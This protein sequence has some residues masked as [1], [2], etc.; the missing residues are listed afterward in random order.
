Q[1][2]AVPGDLAEA[3]ETAVDRHRRT[4][5]DAGVDI[6]LDIEELDTLAIFDPDAIDH[7]MDN[8]LDNA[9]KHTRG[10]DDRSVRVSVSSTPNAVYVD[11]VDSGPGVPAGRR[12]AVFEPFDRGLDNSHTVGLGLGLSIARALARAQSGDLDLV[13]QASQG[14]H[15]RLTLKSVSPR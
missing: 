11:V 1:V 15:L 6:V 9:E 13:N 7:I 5:A 10:S 2:E 4:Y 14:A 8:L 12:R 3:I